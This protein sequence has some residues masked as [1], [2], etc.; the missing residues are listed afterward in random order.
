MGDYEIVFSGE[1]Q[2]GAD[3]QQVRVNLQQLFKASA[4]RIEALFCGRPLVIKS[5]LDRVTAEKYQAL[6][7]RAGARVEWVVADKT[8]LNAADAAANKPI[9]PSARADDYLTSAF[10]HID[11]PDFALAPAGSDMQAS[12]QKQV[13]PA[14]DLAALSIAPTGSDMGQLKQEIKAVQA[15]ISHLKLQ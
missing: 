1:L 12:Y 5:G 8:Q 14:L 13:A 2:P 6:L 15:D 9:A 4:E 3:A 7:A 11:A 10:G